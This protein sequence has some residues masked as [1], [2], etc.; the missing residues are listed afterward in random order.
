MYAAEMQDRKKACE[1]DQGNA[2]VGKTG[3][4]TSLSSGAEG[5]AYMYPILRRRWYDVRV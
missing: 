2:R 3:N 1:P 5:T 4:S